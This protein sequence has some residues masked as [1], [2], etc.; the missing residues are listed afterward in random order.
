M[1]KFSG[2]SLSKLISNAQK[3]SMY[4]GAELSIIAQGEFED[5]A[6]IDVNGTK[7]LIST[8]FG[9]LIGDDAYIGGQ[10]AALNAISDIYASG[11]I[12]QYAQVILSLDDSIS[13]DIAE[14]LLAGVYA[15]CAKEKVR[16]VGGHT[17]KGTECLIGLSNF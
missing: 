1:S 7:L 2:C 15:S 14:Q 4:E 9:P 6:E 3:L 11:G 13:N 12:P 16:I 8:D 17:I 5:C 10:I